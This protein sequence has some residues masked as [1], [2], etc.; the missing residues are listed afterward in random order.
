[1][2]KNFLINKKMKL[3]SL[4]LIGAAS[5]VRH[6]AHYDVA[7]RWDEDRPHPGFPAHWDDFAGVEHL[8]AYSRKLPEQFDVEGQ[9][10]DQFMWS[11]YDN[12]AREATTDD[13]KPTGKFIFKPMDARAPCYE[14]LKTHMGLT[15]KAADDYMD[16]NFD[17]TFD[18]FDTANQGFIEAERMS[19]FFRYFTG[20]MQ[21]PLH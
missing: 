15:G 3:L 11:M 2:A 12:Y 10:G 9:G 7:T 8:G 6:K 13:G 19:S 20:N 16:K 5:A 17:A 21:I 14:I 18:H 1:M 4:A